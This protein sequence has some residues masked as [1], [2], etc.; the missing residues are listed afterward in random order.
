MFSMRLSYVFGFVI[1]LLGVFML[2]NNLG[3]T[4]VHMGSILSTYWP[5]IFIYLG[6]SSLTGRFSQEGEPSLRILP[7][8]RLVGLIILLVGV[9]L[10]GRNL[11][12]FQVDLSLFW[13]LFWPIV[14]ILFGINILKGVTGTGGTN[15]AIMSG[16]EK[17]KE[18]WEL[19][20][21][22]YFAL[23]GGIDLDLTKARIPE[24]ETVL[25][26][27]AIMGGIDVLVSKDIPI[28]CEGMALLGGVDFFQDGGGGILMNR[29]FM[30]KGHEGSKKRLIIHCRT[31]MGG[32]D[33]KGV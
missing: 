12:L 29:R 23:M 11:D 19:K 20:D 1:I 7:G 6:L 14:I 22:N 3:L 30:N 18:A 13:N 28:E 21:K 24:G 26:L 9:L 10:L 17:N 32:I 4:D 5:V 33:I 15:W 25:S 16:I 8:E 27:T 2:L 31:L